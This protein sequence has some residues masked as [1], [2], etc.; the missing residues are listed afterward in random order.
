MRNNILRRYLGCLSFANL[1]ALNLW[2]DSQRLQPRFVDYYRAAPAG[3]TM[4]AATLL[5]VLT[6]SVVFFAIVSLGLRVTQPRLA[7]T[8]RTAVTLTFLFPV[9]LLDYVVRSSDLT[10]PSFLAA[11]AV[12]YLGYVGVVSAAVLYAVLQ[13]EGA[14]RVLLGVN[15]ALVPLLLVTLAGHMWSAFGQEKFSAGSHLASRT[16]V[17]R[18]RPSGHPRILW[19]LFDEFD[20]NLGFVSRPASLD[21]PEFDRLRRE[22]LAADNAFPAA[23]ETLLALPSL[24]SGQQLCGAQILGPSGLSLCRENG[25]KNGPWL[26]SETIFARLLSQ[27]SSS[28]VVGWY[29]P[30]CR[31]FPEALTACEFVASTNTVLLVRE[32][33]ARRVGTVRFGWYLLRSQFA[34]LPL[35]PPA[36]S[37]DILDLGR[38]E[39]LSEFQKIH[40]AALK[41]AVDPELDFA[42]FHYPIPHP[43]GIYDRRAGA[44]SVR[45]EATYIDNMALADRVLGEIRRGLETSGLWERTALVISSDHALRHWD[46]LLVDGLK[47]SPTLGGTG[48]ERIPFFVRLPGETVGKSYAPRVNTLLTGDLILAISRGELSTLGEV[49]NWLQKR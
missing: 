32:A 3:H 46:S 13:K 38:I 43:Y 28:G 16:G 34:L 47:H 6:L 5:V 24:I 41:Y 17:R 14:F 40:A 4:V 18:A 36:I 37:P 10:G 27:G 9:Y 35:V 26:A 11:K 45:P 48:L 33:Y 23:P 19:V 31:L 39:Q 1:C 12:V 22:S 20:Y 8:L 25:R 42:M 30:Y 49:E 7:L 44:F 21:L 29:H 2:H 15:Q